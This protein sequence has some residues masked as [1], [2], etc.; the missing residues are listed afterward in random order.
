MKVT[1]ESKA[2]KINGF[3]ALLV[4]FGTVGF[5]VWFLFTMV[6]HNEFSF[7]KMMFLGLLGFVAVLCL[8]G[9]SSIQPNES[10]VLTFFG[11]YIGSV[12]DDG[13]WWVNPFSLKKKILLRVRNFE[14]KIIK[15]NDTHGNPVEIG[16]VVVWK[17]IDTAKAMFDV[18]DYERYVELQSETAI[19]HIATQY[20]YDSGETHTMSLRGNTDEVCEDLKKELQSKLQATG[21]E[22]LEARLSHLAYSPEIAQAMLRRQQA[23]AVISARQKIVEGAVGMVE[24]ALKQLSDNQ[25]VELD[26][27]RK[28]IMV[29]NLL[30]TLV[31]ESEAKPV[32]NT[33][34]IY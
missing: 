33:G 25:I 4:F 6:I 20:P 26:D 29:N 24:M 19:R 11:K 16:A 3:F 8:G 17:V 10:I 7:L 9:F 21:I 12:R 23:E 14:S 13:F 27:E 28:A 2:F 34:N 5:E 31:S 30:V 1:Q 32:I 22:I 15:V 18:E